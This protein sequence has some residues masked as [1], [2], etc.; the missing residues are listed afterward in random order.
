MKITLIGPSKLFISGISIY[1][2]RLANALSKKNQISVVCLRKLLPRILFPGKKRIGENIS[3]FEFSKGIRIFDGVNYASPLSWIGALRFIERINPDVVIFQWWSSSVLH[4]YIL[5]RFFLKVKT[6]IVVEMHEVIDPVESRTFIVRLY[7]KIFGRFFLKNLD[8]YITHSEHD[9]KLVSETYDIDEKRIKVIPHGLYDQYKKIDRK[10]AKSS[11]NIE[12]EFV[13][14]YFGLIRRY[15]GVFHLIDAFE[16]L[17]KEI[18]EKSRLVLVGEI[19][20]EEK[21]LKKRIDSSN[22]RDRITLVDRYVYDRELENFFSCADVVVLPYLRASQSG[23]AH[24]AMAYGKPVVVSK[25]GGLGEALEIY[26]GTFFV[27]PEVPVDI[28]EKITKVYKTSKSYESPQEYRWEKVSRKYLE[29][30]EDD[31]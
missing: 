29:F 11:L 1:T 30:L 7:S 28:A 4:T 25:V 17:P 21:K 15:K 18:L 20:D 13:I 22:L 24:I 27:N 14:L 8:G 6:K 23:V 9:K 19:W 12:E 26:E 5:I 2:I 10:I 31:F 3:N 16:I